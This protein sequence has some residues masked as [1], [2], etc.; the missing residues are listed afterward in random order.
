MC[1]P[2]GDKIELGRFVSPETYINPCAFGGTLG[3]MLKRNRILHVRHIPAVL[4]KARRTQVANTE[5][6]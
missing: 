6:L 5:R 2:K 1:K 3:E 4:G